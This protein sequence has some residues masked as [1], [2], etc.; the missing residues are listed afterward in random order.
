MGIFG[1]ASMNWNF[2]RD[3]FLQFDY[4]NGVPFLKDLFLKKLGFV[5]SFTLAGY[6]IT[7]KT[8]ADLIV[9]IDTIP[10]DITYDLLQFDFS[11]AFKIINANHTMKAGFSISRY[12]SKLGEFD[13][14]LL[15]QIPSTSTNYFN[16]RDL[17][18]TYV[19]NNFRPSRNDDINPI[20]RY[21]KLKYDYEFNYLNPSLV[22]NEEGNVVEEFS[23]AKFHR[24]E[25]E[26]DE[27]F[28]L[29]KSHSLGFKLKAGSILGPQWITSLISTQAVS[30]V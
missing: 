18:L 14:P 24:L 7:R 16:G 19:Y 30:P 28:P 8:N 6:N 11:M 9:G 26:W 27:S 15:G 25:G 23:S 5:P 17:S 12:S 4:N 10:V 29:F 21:F 20:G 2:E 13:I 1:G 3:L 22:V